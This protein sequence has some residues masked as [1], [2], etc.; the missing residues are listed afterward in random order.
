M[1]SFV[2]SCQSRRPENRN[3]NLKPVRLTGKISG[4][5]IAGHQQ[6]AAGY[7]GYTL[8]RNLYDQGLFLPG[9]NESFCFQQMQVLLYFTP[10]LKL[11]QNNFPRT[12]FVGSRLAIFPGNIKNGLKG[13]VLRLHKINI[14]YKMEVIIFS[15]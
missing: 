1:I 10:V 3:L 2:F 6:V 8:V 4:I 15:Y 9:I 12:A 13:L 11:P 5:L 7:F 14:L